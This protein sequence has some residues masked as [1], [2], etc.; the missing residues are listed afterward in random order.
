MIWNSPLTSLG[1]IVVKLFMPGM[2][3]RIVSVIFGGDE[4][5][6]L[7]CDVGENH[8]KDGNTAFCG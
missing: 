6:F 7:G 5:S 8:L 1:G 4:K 3:E 2:V